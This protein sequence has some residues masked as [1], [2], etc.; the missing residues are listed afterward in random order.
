M[1]KFLVMVAGVAMLATSAVNAQERPLRLFYSTTGLS[2]P[3]N[4]NSPA[5]VPA[6]LGANPS[7]N[8]NVNTA[9]RLYVWAQITPP[10]APNQVTYNGVHLIN[11]LTG[12]GGTVSGFRFWNYTNGDFGTTGRWQNF[13]QSAPG[14]TNGI[15]FAG[16]AVTTGAGVT[17]QN[18]PI[19][20]DGQHKRFGADG[21]TRIDSTL[22]GWIEVQ[23]SQIGELQLRFAVGA[24]GIAQSGDTNGPNRIYMGWGDEASAP[25]GN[26]TGGTTAVADAIVN[27]VPEPASL[28]LLGLAGLALRRR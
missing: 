5:V 21:T 23:G 8:V 15:S 9:T 27:V 14:T 24:S 20:T 4:V 13:T 28:M 6:N 16:A 22:L 19:A 10:G 7:I 3:N 12:A 2:D 17:N 1:K 18:T 26:Q 11:N 25:L